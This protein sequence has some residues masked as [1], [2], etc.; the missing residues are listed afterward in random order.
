MVGDCIYAD[1]KSGQNAGITGIPVFG[2]E[3]ARETLEAF[4]DKPH[5]A[6]ENAGEILLPLKAS[7]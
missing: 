7:N 2:G 5:L 6:L 4:P 3:P 1:V